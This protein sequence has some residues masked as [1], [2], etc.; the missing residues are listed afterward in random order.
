MIIQTYDM[1]A[2]LQK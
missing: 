2:F 1:K